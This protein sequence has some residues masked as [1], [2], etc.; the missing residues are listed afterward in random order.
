[1]ILLQ[2]QDMDEVAAMQKSACLSEAL[3]WLKRLL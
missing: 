3:F 1:M 2:W